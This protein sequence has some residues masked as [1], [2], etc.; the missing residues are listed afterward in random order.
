MNTHLYQANFVEDSYKFSPLP[1]DGKIPTEYR[2]NGLTYTPNEIRYENARYF[3]YCNHELNDYE[4]KKLELD[5][6]D[7]P[8]SPK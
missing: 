2:S 7:C 6:A 4:G 8:Y 3:I 5:W 1:D